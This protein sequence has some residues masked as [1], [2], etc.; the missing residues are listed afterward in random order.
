MDTQAKY[1][2]KISRF[3]VAPHT[4]YIPEI[5]GIITNFCKNH[6]IVVNRIHLKGDCQKHHEYFAYHDNFALITDISIAAD[7]Y[8]SLKWLRSSKIAC[9]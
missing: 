5:L 7:M 3:L 6:G 1:H 8:R 9:L 4:Q 2:D